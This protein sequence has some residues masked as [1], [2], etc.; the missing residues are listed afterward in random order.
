MSTYV[1]GD[2]QGC[3]D[4][5]QD[6]LE[7]VK[8][9]RSNDELIVAGDLINRGPRNLDTIKFLQDLPNLRCV[10]GNHDL[11]FLAVAAKQ[12]QPG[13]SDTL[14]DL[15]ES[16]NLSELKAW[17]LSHP[18][19][20]ALEDQQS[21]I[22]HAG[23]PHIWSYQ[24]AIA[25][26]LE[27][28]Q[29]LADDTRDVFFA[30]MYG[31]EPASLTSDLNGNA[32]LRVITNYLT[33]MR[34]CNKA[35]ELELKSKSDVAPEGYSPWF[36]FARSDDTRILFG[37]WAAIGGRTPSTQY[38]ALDTGCVWGQSLTA[39]RLEDNQKYSVPARRQKKTVS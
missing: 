1:V 14:Q 25:Y 2:I 6:L 29:V 12:K 24:E 37:H 27:V 26:A 22:V 38:V 33:R 21:L 35:G 11:H 32:R 15:L 17:L 7:K 36:D 13:K 39:M 16:S 8:F 9:S 18:L 31:D 3:L 5:L 34:F 20:I 10:L 19:L 30:E 23:I 28:E 4:E